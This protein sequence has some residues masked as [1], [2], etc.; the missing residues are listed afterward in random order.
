MNGA[1]STSDV[2]TAGDLTPFV[3]IRVHA[4]LRSANASNEDNE[5]L[6]ASKETPDLRSLRR[7]VLFQR[8]NARRLPGGDTCMG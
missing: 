7:D 5:T 6:T 8:P 3:F 1:S 4:P 2:K